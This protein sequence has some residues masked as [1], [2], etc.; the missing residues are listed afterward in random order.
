MGWRRKHKD[1]DNA[2]A[3]RKS[4][5]ILE[6][7]RM[8]LVA[9][10]TELVLAD[11]EGTA[12]L[13]SLLDAQVDDSWPPDLYDREPMRYALHQLADPAEQGWSF[14]YLLS[15]VEDQRVVL[16][17]CGFKGRPDVYG[18]VEIGYSVLP[19]FRNQGFATEAVERLVSWAFSHQSVLEVRAETLPHLQQSI[20]VM[21]KN[22]FTYSGKGS[23][24]GVV[25]YMVQRPDRR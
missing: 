21:K 5:R 17:I 19:R 13:A 25:R 6:S 9:A 11:L 22:G 3:P 10:T 16:G 12:K 20:R 1:R 15:N 7:R 24:R 18:S 2:E 8:T 23:E 14:W 4:L